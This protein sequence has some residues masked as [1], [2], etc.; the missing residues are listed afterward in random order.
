VTFRLLTSA[1]AAL[2]ILDQAHSLQQLACAKLRDLIGIYLCH[3][4]DYS[5]VQFSTVKRTLDVAR[6]LTVESLR[7]HNEFS[8]A[9]DALNGHACTLGY[10]IDESLGTI[11]NSTADHEKQYHSVSLYLIQDLKLLPSDLR[12]DP[13]FFERFFALQLLNTPSSNLATREILQ[14]LVVLCHE[15]RSQLGKRH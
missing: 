3:P 13:R 2:E 14:T 6:N 11:I 10:M 15:I 9:L 5:D 1:C 12:F 4:A 8:Q 7:F